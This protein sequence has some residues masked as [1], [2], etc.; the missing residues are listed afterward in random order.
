MDT[1]YIAWLMHTKVL[2]TTSAIFPLPQIWFVWHFKPWWSS[3]NQSFIGTTVCLWCSVM[4]VSDP[5]AVI[6][7]VSDTVKSPC[8]FLVLYL[9]HYMCMLL[10][11]KARIAV[12]RFGAEHVEYESRF[13]RLSCEL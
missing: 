4:L 8:L 13:K 12:F 3:D 2:G 5:F 7:A 11:S 1:G 9:V 10:N 6:S